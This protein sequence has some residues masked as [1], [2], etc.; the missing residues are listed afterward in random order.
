[1][2]AT[3]NNL[4]EGDMLDLASA[5]KPSSQLSPRLVQ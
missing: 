2:T 1:M 5:E 3:C 4:L